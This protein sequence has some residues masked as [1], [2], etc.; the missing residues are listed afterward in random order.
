MPRAAWQQGGERPG[1]RRERGPSGRQVGDEHREVVVGPRGQRP[2]QSLVK[3]V[4]R[5]PPVPSGDPERLGDL[6]PV[7]V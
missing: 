6:V 2:L 3:L 1:Q 4:R 7:L 5:E